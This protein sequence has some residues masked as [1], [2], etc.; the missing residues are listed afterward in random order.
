[1]HAKYSLPE[2]HLTADLSNL[3]HQWLGNPGSQII[4]AMGLSSFNHSCRTFP[5]AD[6]EDETCPVSPRF[7]EKIHSEDPV[8]QPEDVST[9]VD[10]IHSSLG[11]NR[12]EATPEQKNASHIRVIGPRHP[13]LITNNILPY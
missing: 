10:E 6:T 5:E 1:M 3:W 13:T 8:P 11:N 4:G 12:S 2:T 7:V 9:V